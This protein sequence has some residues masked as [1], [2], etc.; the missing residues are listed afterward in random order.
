MVAAV[1][2]T[3]QAADATVAL[4]CQ[5]TMAPWPR[6]EHVKSE[7]VSMDII[8]NL[9][10]RTVQGFGTTRLMDYP[11]KIT[12]VNEVTVTFD[13]TYETSSIMGSINRMTGDMEAMVSGRGHL[14]MSYAL[15][16]RPAQRQRM[17]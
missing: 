7:P 16:C 3:A 2:V 12:G 13:D 11:V 14:L 5:G 10:A 6:T 9:T 8:I 4:A 15:K 17:F 1:P